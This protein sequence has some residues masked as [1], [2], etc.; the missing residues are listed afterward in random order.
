MDFEVIVIGS[1]AGGGFAAAN[2]AKSGKKV[3]I[4][5]RGQDIERVQKDKPYKSGVD[6]RK[7]LLN[8]SRKHLFMGD[9]IGGSTSIYGAVLI[10]P[11]AEDFSPGQHL[12]SYLD[13]ED[14]D[15]PV[16]YEEFVPYFEKVEKHFSMHPFESGRLPEGE[17][18]PINNFIANNWEQNG[19]K[20][21]ILPLAIDTTSCLSC[22]DCP[23]YMCP[24]QSRGSTRNMILHEAQDGNNLT[25]WTGHEVQSIDPQKSLVR[26][27]CLESG[28]M[29][30]LR[31]NVIVL[32][33]GAINSAGIMLRSGVDTTHPHI[34]KNFM[35][36]AGAVSFSLFKKPS[37]G[38]Q[39]FIKQLGLQDYYFGS[40]DYPHKLGVFQ[41]L[42]TPRAAT[43]PIRNHLYLMMATVEDLPVTTN[44]V[45]LDSDGRPSVAHKFHDYDIQRSKYATKL[46]KKLMHDGGAIKT[47]TATAD[48]NKTHVGHQ[49]GTIRF[50]KSLKTS[51]LDRWCR[52]HGLENLFVV[53]GSFMPTS[54]GASP[55]LTIMANG[56]RV[57]DFIIRSI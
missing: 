27:R 24:N 5:E 38:G 48:M 53:D 4:L 36:H 46:L 16:P 44:R 35:Y 39:R 55:A 15:W 2:L 50:G 37:Q 1:G 56:L 12:S 40:K 34:G 23:G 21:G 3:L 51:V 14:Y 18:A 45:T 10:R 11:R 17:L 31:S 26:V 47:M 41:S 29:K 9:V 49:V 13:E 7:Y 32:S 8:G 52:P 22:S 57:S 28:Q 54:M 20:P 30:E 43:K 42:P 6:Q 19:Y 33:A 25:L